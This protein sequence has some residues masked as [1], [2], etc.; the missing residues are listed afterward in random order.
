MG[1]NK[2]TFDEMMS[3]YNSKLQLRNVPVNQL[4]A[5]HEVTGGISFSEITYELSKLIGGFDVSIESTNR[6]YQNYRGVAVYET[7]IDY[8]VKTEMSLSQFERL[9]SSHMQLCELTERLGEEEAARK[10][11][12]VKKAYDH[13]ITLV[14][15]TN[16]SN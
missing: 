6:E 5:K 16:S 1:S 12:A 13:Y 7:H 10:N 4:T 15:L 8:R 9:A 14:Q 2:F 11:P 3:T